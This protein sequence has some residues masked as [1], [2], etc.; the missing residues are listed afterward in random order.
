MIGGTF[1]EDSSPFLRNEGK[2]HR[3]NLVRTF[4]ILHCYGIVILNHAV[5][6]C[7][8]IVLSYMSRKQSISLDQISNDVYIQIGLT[9]ASNINVGLRAIACIHPDIRT[10]IVNLCFGGTAEKRRA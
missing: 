10:L 8:T 5:A 3:T 9:K 4:V 6:T 1:N 2:L 7:K